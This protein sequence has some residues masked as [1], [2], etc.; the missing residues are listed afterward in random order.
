MTLNV[1]PVDRVRAPIDRVWELL[2]QPAGYGQFWDL[3][4]ERVE[5]D[6]P[7]VTGQKLV[8][9]SR[10]LG[11]RWRVEGEIQDVDAEMHQILFRMSLPLGVVGHNRIVCAPI[12]EG[13]CTLRFG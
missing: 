12:D 3:T 7:A 13:S 9:W 1:C 4:V 8:G 11:R 5:P 2:V 6:G 10:A